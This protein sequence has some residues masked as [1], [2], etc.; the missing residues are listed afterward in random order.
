MKGKKTMKM[1]NFR[2]KVA[3]L[4]F[5]ISF[6]SY[7][8]RV[9]LSVATPVIMKEFGF[10]KIDMGLIQSFF[11]AGYALM[12][13]PGGM[14]AEKFGHRFTGSIA[15]AWWSIFTALTAVASGKYT[16]AIVRLMFGLGEA[17]IYPAFAMAEHKWFNKDEKGK[18]SSFI[19]N[20]CFFGPVVGPAVVVW[21]MTTFGWHHVFLSF[22]VVGLLL[23]WAW[24]KYVTDDPKDSP[25]VNEA[26]LA[27][28]NEGRVEATG[29]KQ[30][31][32]WGKLL[33]SSQ[34]WALGIQFLITDY[35]MYV[36][37]AWLPMYLMEVHK[38]SLAKMGIWAAAPWISLMAVVT[39]C[40]HYS[41][42]LLRN[43]MSQNMVKTATGAAGILL[44]AGALYISTR[45]ADPMINVLWL[46]VSLGSLGLTM[47][48]SWSSVITM[49]GKFAGS[50]SGWMNFWG[51]IGGVLAPTVTA[52][53][54]TNYGWQAA[55]AATAVTGICGAI[56]WFF[57]KPDKAIV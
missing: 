15:C 48:A 46:S 17:P 18:A 51:N 31:A 25:Y 49:G 44:C 34:F 39:L 30:I 27:H 22:G 43:G 32:P 35:I 20:G 53:F 56:A 7:M 41:D 52:W 33:R 23:A 29:E 4:I 11:F 57:V 3:W 5:A 10:T 42:K 37:L 24:H 6:V 36:F 1:T 21:L 38:F 16:F 45:T 26:E 50:V 9:N 13:V 54:A 2:W 28:I 40:G 12:Q 14:V 19:L 55:L 8:D 47:S